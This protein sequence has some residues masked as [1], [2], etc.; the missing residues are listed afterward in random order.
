MRTPEERAAFFLAIER[1]ED[2]GLPMEARPEPLDV[3]DLVRHL[4]GTL[5]EAQTPGVL[6]RLSRSRADRRLLLSVKEELVDLQSL[7]PV[8]LAALR[9][10]DSLRA[11]VADAWLSIVEESVLWSLRLGLDQGRVSFAQFLRGISAWPA[12]KL[13]LRAGLSPTIVGGQGGFA[14][15]RGGEAPSVQVERDG[16][17][18]RLTAEVSAEWE[19]KEVMFLLRGDLVVLF[20]TAIVDSGKAS[21]TLP[22][23]ADLSDMVDWERV[24]V[25]ETGTGP[26][27]SGYPISAREGESERAIPPP[28]G[29]WPK[30]EGG[31]IRISVA[32]PEEFMARY[33][34]RAIRFYLEIAPGATQF[35][36]S[37]PI[38]DPAADLRFPIPHLPEETGD[39]IGRLRYTVG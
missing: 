27:S 31:E 13:H 37:Y 10:H 39:F 26:K 14:V 21:V 29:D 28:L 18:L 20:G 12:A 11:R 15:H 35:L 6:H 30:F 19:G 9:G 24:E 38:G 25:E 8:E 22:N 4:T 17:D 7:R 3:P 32:F 36:E 33:A 16:S 2:P 23:I 34:G 5:E 1:G